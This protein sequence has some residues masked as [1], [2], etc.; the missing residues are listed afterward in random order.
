[1]AS[2]KREGSTAGMGKGLAEMRP[3]MAI[4]CAFRSCL[5]LPDGGSWLLASRSLVPRWPPDTYERPLF[6]PN[7]LIGRESTAGSNI[8]PSEHASA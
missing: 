6:C 4:F 8:G 3:L 1:M 5:A 2:I 7:Q